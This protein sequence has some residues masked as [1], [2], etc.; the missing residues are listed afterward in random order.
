MA[1]VPIEI[2]CVG[3]DHTDAIQV[4]IGLL[5][6]QQD[7]FTFS[8]L[9]SDPCEIASPERPG[10]FRTSEVYGLI[11]EKVAPPPGYHPHVIAVVQHRLRGKQFGNLF[12]SV[13]SAK[14]D[15][16]GRHAIASIYGVDSILSQSKIPIEAFLTFE[17]LSFAM[18]VVVEEPMIHDARRLCV[19]DRKMSKA[20]IVPIISTG[21][22]CKQCRAILPH[23]LD[24]DQIIAADSI[25]RILSEIS[26]SDDPSVMYEAHRRAV[27]N[28][29]PRVFL[30]HA[31]SDR[32][33]TEKLAKGLVSN[34]LRV[35]FDKWE[36][37]ASDEIALKISD[38][39][40]ACDCT[41]LT[42]SSRAIESEWVKREWTTTLHACLNSPEKVLLVPVMLEECK[43]PRLLDSIH[44]IDFTCAKRFDTALEELRRITESCGWLTVWDRG[45]GPR[46]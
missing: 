4:A 9:R 3:H 25:L 7:A 28:G 1:T 16:A 2:V 13:Q 40:D 6:A 29:L 43:L 8:L 5:N 20:D 23:Y 36:I 12:G 10:E 45:R 33:F 15:R 34:G 24:H 44:R 17:F 41:T 22:I 19:F 42:V 37:R 39:L 30:S 21:H 11:T 26:T 32:G 31:S 35:W 46:G 18:R 14:P 27:R 38:A